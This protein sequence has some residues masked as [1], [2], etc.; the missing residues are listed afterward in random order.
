MPAITN[1][2]HDVYYPAL[3]EDSLHVQ[4]DYQFAEEQLNT[5]GCGNVQYIDIEYKEGKINRIWDGSRI[6]DLTED[7]HFKYY[8]HLRGLFRKGFESVYYHP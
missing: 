3:V 6:Y 8:D 5:I 1:L 7:Q 2:Y 4:Q